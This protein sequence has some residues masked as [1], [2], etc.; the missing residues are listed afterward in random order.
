M[1]TDINYYKDLCTVILSRTHIHAVSVLLIWKYLATRK[2]KE[3]TNS[4]HQSGF[5]RSPK[6]PTSRPIAELL[7]SYDITLVDSENDCEHFLSERVPHAPVII[8]LD[9]EWVNRDGVSS[10]PVAL[11]QLAFP[12]GQ[13]L[14]VRVFR[15]T[16]LGPLLTEL[17]TNR[18]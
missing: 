8:G 17:L 1:S 5:R 18:R 3:I 10:A 11:L 12:N 2:R 6:V 4:G 9:C 13:C 7:T 14:L 16:A 15:M